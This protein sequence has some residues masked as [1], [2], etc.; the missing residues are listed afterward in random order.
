VG[1][2]RAVSLAE[3]AGRLGVSVRTIKRM[4]DEGKIQAF[5]VLGQWRIKE[6]EIHRIMNSGSNENAR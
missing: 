5:K 3:A 6:S 1:Q 4:I 2:D